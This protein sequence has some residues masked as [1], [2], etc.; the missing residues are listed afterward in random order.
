MAKG[1]NRKRLVS[2]LDKEFSLV[3]RALGRRERGN[4]CAFCSNPIECCFHYITRSKFKVRWDFD[5]AEASCMGCNYTMEHNPH[6]FVRYYIEK[7]GL[8]KYTQLEDR[9]RGPALYS[10][11]DLEERLERILDM[12]LNL[13]VE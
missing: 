4:K 1:S 8:D 13:G 2:R 3:V 5:N 9:S 10:I 12:K 7:Y 11:S 6:P